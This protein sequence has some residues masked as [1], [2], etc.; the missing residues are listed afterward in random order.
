[1]I[2]NSPDLASVIRSIESGG[3]AHARR[4]EP[5]VY[6]WEMDI[7]GREATVRHIAAV[8]ACSLGTAHVMFSESY[9]AYQEMG[10]NLWDPAHPLISV[11]E[12]TFRSDPA[13]Q[14]QAFADF[15]ERQGIAW[16]LEQLLDDDVKLAR[17]VTVWNG[18]GDVA[19]Y[20]ARF[21]QVAAQQQGVVSS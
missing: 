6:N 21:R 1:M 16:T 4:F 19:V 12:F 10:F 14:A 2:S 8:N 9:G 15:I 13:L 11:D 7:Y 3:N 5:G 20:T 18:P 17:F